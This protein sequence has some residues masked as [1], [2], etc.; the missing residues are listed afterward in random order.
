MSAQSAPFAG[1][2]D[3]ILPRSPFFWLLFLWRN[4][5]KVT[6]GLGRVAPFL[7]PSEIPNKMSL[8]L[9]R[10]YPKVILRALELFNVPAAHLE[11]GFSPQTPGHFLLRPKSNQKAAQG[12]RTILIPYLSQRL[13]AL[14]GCAP[15]A[16]IHS[17]AYPLENPPFANRGIS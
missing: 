1:G 2:A 8:T 13:P 14:W 7:Y 17:S 4:Q 16:Q 5:R 10:C 9:P 11:W 6:G 12:G 15:T 3:S